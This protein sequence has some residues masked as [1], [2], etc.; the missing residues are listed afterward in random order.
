VT[1]TEP[2][3]IANIGYR[4]AQLP[5]PYA[6]NAPLPAGDEAAARAEEGL[7]RAHHL[8]RDAIRNAASG[9]QVGLVLA[10]V[11]WGNTPG[12]EEQLAAFQRQWEGNFWDV[13]DGDDFFGAAAFSRLWMGPEGSPDELPEG[14]NKE[15]ASMYLMY[16]PGTRRTALGY[17]YRPECVEAAIRAGAERTGLP[18]FVAECGVATDDDRERV[19]WI[20]RSLE[21]VARCLAD[22]IDVRGYMVRSLIDEFYWR[23]GF[24]I[25][26]G[27]CEVDWETFE[28]TPKQS[29]RVLG[30][31]ARTGLIPEAVTA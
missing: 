11:E 15:Q 7:I 1:L 12:Y 4:Y 29:A 25:K 31:Y 24:T 27:M 13:L 20:D 26:F 9:A 30:E 8:G 2:D 21:G 6:P 16:P 22:G 17:E 28:R 3:V 23:M 14:S 10:A 5:G 19:E 18:V